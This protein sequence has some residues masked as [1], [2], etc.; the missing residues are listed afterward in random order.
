M[1]E[2]W[3]LA[4]IPRRRW[5]VAHELPDSGEVAVFDEGRSELLLLNA[6]AGM[7]WSLADGNRTIGEIALELMLVAE[8]PPARDEVEAQLL[9]FFADMERRG[10]LGGPD[11]RP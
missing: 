11:E 10:A 7:A 3:T 9:A 1:N 5:L 8:A 4:R 2:E 6:V